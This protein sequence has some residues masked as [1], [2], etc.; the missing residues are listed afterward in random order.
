MAL[1]PLDDYPV[2]QVA[3]VMRHP[4]TSDRNFYDRYYFNCHSC[5]GDLMLIIGIGQYPNLGVT[6]GFALLR[7][8]GR[9]QV[10]RASRELGADRM[11]TS[12]GPLRVEV[13]EGLKTLRVILE[14]NEFGL[15]FDLTWEGTIPAQLEPRHFI[16]WQERAVFD[17]MR[18]SQTGTWRG[19][20]KAGDQAITVTQDRWWGSRDRS[21]GVRPVGEPEPPGIQAKNPAQF[22]WMYAPMQFDGFSILAIVQEDAE[23]ERILE[24][25]VRVWADP[26]RPPERLGRPGYRPDFAP[27][28][29]DVQSAVLSFEPPGGQPFGVTVTP[30]LPVSLMVGTG[31]GLEPNWKHGMYQGRDLVVQGVTY[32]LSND[33]DRARM[34]GMVDS[35]ARFECARGAGQEPAVG[36]GLFEYWALGEHQPTGLMP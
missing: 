3:Q 18:L 12:V 27:G 4:A 31:Y 1:S 21:W 5:S 26:A 13:I 7:Q 24:G 2:H 14:P 22:Y 15:D 25:A 11:D 20:I 23:G 36:Y 32:D 8:G 34:W 9:H 16:R 30:L 28:T 19:H 17:S 29:R 33:G 10:V 6:D 35:V